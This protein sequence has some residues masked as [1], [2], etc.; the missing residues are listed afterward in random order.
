M[1]NYEPQIYVLTRTSN[2]PNSFEKC[3]KSVRTQTYKKIKHI[4]TV[5]NLKDLNYV[6]KHKISPI[7]I[8]KENISKEKDISNPRTG[9][10]FLPNLYLN[11]MISTL[12]DGWIIILDDD[13]YF[14]NNQSVEKIVSHIKYPTD[15]I[16]WQMQYPNSRVLPTLVDFNK[17]PKLGKIGSPCFTIHTSI[18]KQLKFDGWKCGD[19]RFILKA[20]NKTSHKKWIPQPLIKI[21]TNTGGLGNRLDIKKRLATTHPLLKK[22]NRIPIRN[23]IP[24]NQIKHHFDIVCPG[25]NCS[26]Y[27]MDTVKSIE[28]QTKSN[29]FTYTLHLLDDASNDNT[30]KKMIVHSN[31]NKNIKTYRNE[32]N[33]GAAY[34]RWVIL[35][36]LQ[37]KNSIIVLLD[38][39]DILSNIALHEINRIYNNKKIKMTFGGRQNMGNNQFQNTFYNKFIVDSNLYHSVPQMFAPALRTFKSEMIAPLKESFFK[40]VNGKFYIYCTEHGLLLPLLKQ[41]KFE[42]IEVFKSKKLYIYR[43]NRPNSTLKKYTN[44]KK[45]KL[46]AKINNKFKNIVFKNG[47][48]YI[49]NNNT[50]TLIEN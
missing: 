1:E 7:V 33:M 8:N 44:S 6:Q 39:D 47:N 27:L 15:I 5:D 23:G 48:Y 18:A 30:Y 40:D 46:F 16:F 24:K 45:Q 12:D 20:F 29:E 22:P 14:S 9:K 25:W 28:T 34:S 41:C 36:T 26:Q 43:T 37:K 17:V 21:G 19:Y 13:D 11:K 32:K 4:V 49:I 2:R 42:N 10:R 31:K 38:M 50:T 3:L 35:K